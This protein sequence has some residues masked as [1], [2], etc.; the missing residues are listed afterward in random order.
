MVEVLKPGF[1]TTIQDL[2]RIGYREYG[3]PVSGAMDH[4]SARF[5]NALLG[6]DEKDAII[7]ITLIGPTLK[8]SCDTSICI[9]GANMNPKLDEKPIQ[10]NRRIIV[11]K[12]SILTF[13]KLEFGC[14]AYIA[15]AGGFKTEVVMN[16]RSM[17]ANITSKNRVEANDILE[18]IPILENVIRSNSV[19]KPDEGVFN[20]TILEVLKGPEFDML[21]IRLQKQ[22][23]TKE[24]TVSKNNSR[25]GYQLEGRLENNLKSILTGPVLP[26]TV[27]LTPSGK[28]IV[29]M[30]DGQT[31][32]G[33]PRVLQLKDMAINVLS[34]KR[35]GDLIRFQF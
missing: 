27:Q 20:K 22:I 3:V 2:G 25:M 30:R 15:I 5:A 14:R 35:V 6:N 19:I 4:Y 7:E 9:T 12:N 17:Y 33:Y 23:V 21:P 32:G 10:L 24:F 34:H 26:G 11:E 28:L 31:T 29:L 8:F 1:Y 13:G 16:S 18:I